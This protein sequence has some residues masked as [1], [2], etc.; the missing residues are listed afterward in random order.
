MAMMDQHKLILEQKDEYELVWP[1]LITSLPTVV[2][3]KALPT[4]HGLSRKDI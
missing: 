1:R 3:R 2:R 4:G